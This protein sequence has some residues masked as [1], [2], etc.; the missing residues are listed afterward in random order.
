MSSLRLTLLA[1]FGFALS[2]TQHAQSQDSTL[3]YIVTYFETVPTDAP[4]A[5]EMA[6]ELAGASRKD[7]GNLRFEV[8]QRV[9]QTD[10][11]V[12][13]ETWKSKED[14]AAHTKAAHTTQFRQ[15]LAP[16]LRGPYDERPHGGLAVASPAEP[17]KTAGTTPPVYV[18]THVDII[19]PEKDKG[20][21][22][23]RELAEA[24]RRETGNLRFEV[25]QQ[26]NRPNH[27][28]VVEVWESRQ[29]V[30]AHGAAQHMKQFREKLMPMSGSLY[31]ERLYRILN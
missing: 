5:A 7:S 3:V 22:A 30:D 25:L 17:I 24:S 23:T 28:T 10:H 11:F 4:K 26:L 6:R 12:L 15:K 14:H 19:P 27:M 2:V 21:Q 9:G 20:I 18:V 16:L 31:D 29:A 1:L 8:L 13:L